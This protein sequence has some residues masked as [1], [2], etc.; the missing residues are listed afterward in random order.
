MELLTFD[1]NFWERVEIN[2]KTITEFMSTFSFP[3][4]R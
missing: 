4:I 1:L 3:K 2:I